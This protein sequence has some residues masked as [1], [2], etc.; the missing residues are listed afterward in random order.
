MTDYDW[1]PEQARKSL[2]RILPEVEAKFADRLSEVQ[3]DWRK[4]KIR[5][6]CQWE[7]LFTYLQALYGWQYDFF[8]TLERILYSLVDYWLQRPVELKEFDEKRQA[9]PNWFLSEKVVGIVLYVDLFSGNLSKLK[10]HITYFRNL[11][12]SYLHLMPL[13]SVTKV[14]IWIFFYIS[15]NSSF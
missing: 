6:D 4:F 15:M 3:G 13:F 1:K 11:D 10:D 12:I 2:N 7:R 5:L 8:Y 14:A 9:D